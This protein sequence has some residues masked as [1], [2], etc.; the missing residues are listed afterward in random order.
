MRLSHEAKILQDIELANKQKSILCRE[1]LS[2]RTSFYFGLKVG[3]NRIYI[4]GLESMKQ[5]NF[6]ELSN[7]NFK[8]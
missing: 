7:Q 4:I 3:Y 1:I 6:L 8:A 2:A 5:C